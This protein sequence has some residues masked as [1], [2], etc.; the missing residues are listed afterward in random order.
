MDGKGKGKA[1]EKGRN[2]A[3]VLWQAANRNEK[4]PH[5]GCAEIGRDN[6]TNDREAHKGNGRDAKDN[7]LQGNEI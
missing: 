6:S 1:A 4:E 2:E 7:K 5:G 3:R